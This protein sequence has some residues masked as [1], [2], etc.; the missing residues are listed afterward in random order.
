MLKICVD[1]NR[2]VFARLFN[3]LRFVYHTRER[4]LFLIN[5]CQ[6]ISAKIF[7]KLLDP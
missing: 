5:G 2:L 4:F 6:Q 7:K 3:N 1:K